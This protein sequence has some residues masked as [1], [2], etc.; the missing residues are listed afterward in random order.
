VTLGGRKIME[1][2]E[3]KTGWEELS[4]NWKVAAWEILRRM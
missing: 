4:M 3:G 1:G 2:I